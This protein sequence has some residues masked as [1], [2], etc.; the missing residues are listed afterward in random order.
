MN[1]TKDSH[2][3]AISCPNMVEPKT[4]NFH[5]KILS[6]AT[7]F[8]ARNS[9]SVTIFKLSG[10]MYQQRST[11]LL[12]F[13]ASRLDGV[14]LITGSEGSQNSCT[15]AK[16]FQ[17]PSLVESLASPGSDFFYL[18]QYV[19]CLDL[20]YLRLEGQGIMRFLDSQ[21]FIA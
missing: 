4:S 1:F 7:H 13:Q 8:S 19:Y 15:K 17:L 12:C 9:I 3:M 6:I 21:A 2:Q 10:S 20:Q 5:V 16:L 18:C 11:Q 14:V